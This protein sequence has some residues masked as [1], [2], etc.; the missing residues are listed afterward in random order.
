MI[1]ELLRRA[2]DGEECGEELYALVYDHLRSMASAQMRGAQ[3]G[4][5]LQP[6]ALVH[7]AWLRLGASSGDWRDREHFM[8]VAARAMRYALVD[9]I[10]RREAQKRGG[11]VERVELDDAVSAFEERSID[12]VGLHEALELLAARDERQARIVE[13]RFFGGMTLEETARAVEVSVA[14]AERSW[15]L[16]RAFLRHHLEE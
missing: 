1:T 9:R 6:T 12:L 8:A 3:G 5:T 4:M 15:D 10:R 7:E 2:A 11:G 13:L 14:T 16:A